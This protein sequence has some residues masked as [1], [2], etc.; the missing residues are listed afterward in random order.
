MEFF[1]TFLAGEPRFWP[2]EAFLGKKGRV[3]NFELRGHILDEEN[4]GT[5]SGLLLLSGINCGYGGEGPSGTLQILKELC[6]RYFPRVDAASL[7]E[8]AVYGS[9]SI[10]I[11]FRGDRPRLARSQAGEVLNN[12]VGPRLWE[13]LKRTVSH[14]SAPP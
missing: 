11:D 1:R 10:F 6:A 4:P 13:R 8:P 7:F 14:D 2:I 5:S 3:F 9:D 12:R